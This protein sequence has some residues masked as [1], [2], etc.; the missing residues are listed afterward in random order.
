MLFFFFLNII[1][2]LPSNA[3]NAAERFYYQNAIYR[4]E[5]KTVQLY[6]VGNE[7]SNPEYVLGSDV[8]LVLKFDDLAEEAK[9]Y[10]YTII[11]CD[12][13]W[14]ETYMQQSQYIDGMQDNQI[15]DYALSSNTTVKFVNYQLQ[16]PNEDCTP[17]LSGNYALLVFENNDRANLVLIR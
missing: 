8:A 3:S 4:E 1:L 12:A 11:H 7:L 13:D 15:T 14:N 6:R 2:S 5:I 17:K 10:S 9:N 16:I